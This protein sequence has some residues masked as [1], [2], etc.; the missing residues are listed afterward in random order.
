MM[1]RRTGHH[2]SI[3]WIPTRTENKRIKNFEPSLG[4]TYTFGN[5][6]S[7]NIGTDDNDFGTW[8]VV[9]VNRVSLLQRL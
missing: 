4:T 5:H 2:N 9:E 1:P 3:S 8:N 6:V 7:D